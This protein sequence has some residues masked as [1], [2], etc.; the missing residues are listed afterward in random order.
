MTSAVQGRVITATEPVIDLRGQGNKP[1]LFVV[2]SPEEK[3]KK[4]NQYFGERDGEVSKSESTRDDGDDKLETKKEESV[5]PNDKPNADDAK[6][7]EDK[8]DELFRRQDQLWKK[9]NEMQQQET[10]EELSLSSRTISLRT[11]PSFTSRCKPTSIHSL[12]QDRE[13]ISSKLS[14]RCRINGKADGI[15]AKILAPPPK[16]SLSRDKFI[17]L[18]ASLQEA[19]SSLERKAIVENLVPNY[20]ITCDQLGRILALLSFPTE[21]TF[22]ARTL[23]PYVRDRYH[24]THDILPPLLWLTRSEKREILDILISATSLAF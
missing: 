13:S 7:K 22:A 16:P 2:T 4:E 5:M 9:I 12:S 21:R 6:G 20:V 17:Q 24:R 11:A 23:A 8:I 3:E 18:V 10:K 15:L 1:V 14:E 19:G